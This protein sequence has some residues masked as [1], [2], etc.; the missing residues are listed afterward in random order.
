MV[1]DG[2]YSPVIATK[3]GRFSMQTAHQLRKV[4]RIEGVCTATATSKSLIY[5][6]GNPGS[7]YYDAS[8]PARF[9]LGKR[10]VGWD[11]FEIDSW[12]QARKDARVGSKR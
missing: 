5:E 7:K 6:K 8:F 3:N 11:A 1:W 2:L 4:L 10:A 9:K 12:I